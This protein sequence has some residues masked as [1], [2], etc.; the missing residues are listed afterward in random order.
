[1]NKFLIL[2]LIIFG[3]QTD[4]LTDTKKAISEID[5]KAILINSNVSE[6][7]DVKSIISEYKERENKKIKMEF[8]HTKLMDIEQIFYQKNGFIFGQIIKGKDVIIY[9]KKPLKN[10]PYAILLDSKTYFKNET[11]GINFTRKLNIYEND[12]IENIRKKLNKLEFETKKLN[13]EDY[14]RLKEKFDRITKQK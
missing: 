13:K 4:W 5:E 8:S 1:M 9:K 2:V 12:K 7:N 3:L 6:E 10:E 14:I 11:E